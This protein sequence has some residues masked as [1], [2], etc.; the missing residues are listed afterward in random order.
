MKKKIS[1]IKQRNNSDAQSLIDQL[2]AEIIS[3][4]GSADRAIEEIDRLKK[5]IIKRSE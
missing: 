4:A 5:E 3:G 2:E 1:K